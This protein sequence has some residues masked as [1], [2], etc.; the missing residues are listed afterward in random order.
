MCKFRSPL[1]EFVFMRTYSR[2]RDDLQRRET[3]PE[4]V[5][6]VINYLQEK[7]PNLPAKMWKAVKEN[8]LN[9]DVFPAMR[10]L[11]SAGL[12]MDSNNLAGFNC[13]GLLI[14][15]FNDFGEMLYLLLH[16]VGSGF[17][18]EVIYEI[19]E[20]LIVNEDRLEK[21]PIIPIKTEIASK[22]VEFQVKD[23]KEGWKD[24][25]DFLF[26]T[27]MDGN[28]ADFDYS[29]VRPKGAKL[30]TFGG[31]ACLTG[32]S[33]VYKDRKKTE[34]YNTL[35]LSELHDL[36]NSKGK[37]SGVP[38][39][40]KNV[41]IRSLDEDTGKFYRNK[42]IDI[43]S[44][45]ICDI[46]KITTKKGY[47]IKATDNHR[48]L[49]E[50][51]DYKYV[52]DFKIGDSIGVNGSPEKKTGTCID[53]GDAVSRRAV[54][55]RP[56]CDENQKKEDCLGSTAR[57]RKENI[58]ARKDH[59]EFCG[60][61]AEFNTEK[62]VVCLQNHHKDRDPRNNDISNLITVCE[63]CHHN[64]H[65]HEDNLG[66]PY[67]H[68]YLNFDQIV[69]IDACGQEE[70]F[71]VAMEAPNHNFV[72][73]GFVSHNS[74]P[75]PLHQLHQF[76]IE[77]FHKA[78]GRRLNS[79]EVHDICCEIAQIVIVGG[80]RRSSL[81]SMSCLSDLLH[82]NLKNGTFPLRRYMSNNTAIYDKKP[83]I[84]DFMEEWI[85]LAK[86]GSGER[87]IFN[88]EAAR[89]LA[90]KRRDAKKLMLS[91]P[92][93]EII[94]RDKFLCNLSSVVVRADDTV[95]TLTKKCETAAWL[96]TIQAS[97]TNF[98]NMSAEWKQNADEEAL[99][100]VSLAGEMDNPQLLDATTLKHLKDTVIRTNKK[101]A[102]ILGVKQAAACTC[103]K[104]E[105]TLSLVADCGA[106]LHPYWSPY[107]VRRVRISATD[108]LCKV[109]QCYA[110]IPLKPE[111][112][113]TAENCTTWVVEFP[114]KAPS[115]AKF[116][117]DMNAI[118]QLKW[119]LHVMENYV[120]H[121]A[122]MTCYVKP[123]EWLKVGAFVYENFDK[124]VAVSFLPDD[125]GIYS[126]APLEEITKE[127]Y[128]ARANVFPVID[129]SLL[130]LYEKD[131]MTEG[132]KS[133]ACS[134]SNCTL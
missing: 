11:W 19:F 68:R 87:G 21:F 97:F 98:P 133:Y 53:C 100:A 119:Y 70:V 45:G 75:G 48:F 85:I 81:I 12:P 104:P 49:C 67:A 34:G 18:L 73:S 28:D 121:N 132:A 4:V 105:G 6:R 44:N 101:A 96:G 82:A 117:K 113:Q 127:E 91:N 109:L 110:D 120:E 102:K 115:T 30:K 88:R 29:L 17:S 93:A 134:G 57:Q 36:K 25:L 79:K 89:R 26:K 76:V 71:D 13:S 125:C 47:I 23:S 38:N 9:F 43:I 61:Q 118:D 2:W 24:S 130:S 99:I 108:P 60:L 39:H 128:E 66:D 64:I 42:V 92:C 95:A 37:W 3:Y 107:Y 129:Y 111:N 65:K 94:G 27:L 55:C 58:E 33:V 126:L 86:S 122:S 52:M 103:V 80:V 7:R 20:N 54:R 116:K 40:F 14:K 69:S 50:T 106:G 63:P 41:K 51:G 90:P 59:C 5:D 123:D 131:D 56:C 46:F 83:N 15:E 77:T 114:C 124:I 1:A 78:Q 74:G 84:I 10:L 35:T 31:R 16:G 112:G 22:T 72:A 62:G 32:D 8:M